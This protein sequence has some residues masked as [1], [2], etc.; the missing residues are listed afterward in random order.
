[1]MSKLVVL[2]VEDEPLIRMDAADFIKGAGYEV[3]EAAHADEAMA[4]L[5]ARQDIAVVFTDIEMPGS[6]DGIKLAHS[7]R[8]DWPLV[9]VVVASGRVVPREGDLPA[10]VRYLKKPYRPAEVIEAL[11]KAVELIGS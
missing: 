2:V 11:Q 5:S 9:I 4:I 1:M 3:L 10:N 6:M 8:L 7:V